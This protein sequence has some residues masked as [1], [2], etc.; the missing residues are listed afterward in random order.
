MKY[1]PGFKFTIRSQVNR[2]AI[3]T[4]KTLYKKHVNVDHIIPELKPNVEYE[5]HQIN[6]KIEKGVATSVTY[7]FRSRNGTATIVFNHVGD[8]ESKIDKILGVDQSQQAE[9]ADLSR[10]NVKRDLGKAAEKYFNR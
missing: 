10:E 6:P 9:Q 7:V 5:I 8:A 3:K 4:I 1:I 2:S